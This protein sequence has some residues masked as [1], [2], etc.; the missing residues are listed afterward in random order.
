MT[1]PLWQ[2]VK[3]TSKAFFFFLQLFL[4]SL[5]LYKNLFIVYFLPINVLGSEDTLVNKISKGPWS[6]GYILM[7]KDSKQVNK[8]MIKAISEII[9][10]MRT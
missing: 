6:P 3:R 4:L 10:V 7:G 8:K 5:F 1:P 2:K 9:S